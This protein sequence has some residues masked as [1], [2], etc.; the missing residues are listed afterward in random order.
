M[1]GEYKPQQGDEAELFERY[2]AQLMRRVSAVVRTSPEI[3]EDACSIAWAHFLRHQPDRNREWRAWLFRTAQREAW[4]LDGKRRETKPLDHDGEDGHRIAEPSDPRD[5]F[6]ERDE[7]EAAV[8]VI[9]QLPP[10]L[11]RIAFLRATG[12]RYKEIQEIT[13][14]SQTRVSQLIRR[15]NDHIRD[16]L[17][18]LEAAEVALPPKAVRLRELES[19]PPDWLTRQIGEPPHGRGGREG[20]ATRLLGWRRA[21]LAIEDY[22]ELTGYDSEVHALGPRPR[23]EAYAKAFDAAQRAID[24]L[25]QQRSCGRGL[26]D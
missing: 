13:G 5:A 22:R 8:E 6:T 10:R 3:I 23:P 20:Y 2:N 19:D 18:E 7:L 25:A 24:A 15:A 1:A 26:G 4:I 21:A 16:A 17:Q 12:H 11:R 14:D 9:G